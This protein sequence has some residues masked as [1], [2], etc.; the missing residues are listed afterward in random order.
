RDA[1][2]FTAIEKQIVPGLFARNES[3]PIRIWVVGC[4]TGEEVYS[5]VMLLSEYAST[6]TNPAPISVFAT[7]ID[8]EA[9]AFARTGLY[10]DTIAEQMTPERL[11]RFFVREGSGYRIAKHLREMV[12]FAV[13]N[14]IQD[15]PFS[16]VDLVSCRNV[17]IY[18]NR[19]LQS[20]VLDL[21]HFALRP[22]GTLILGMSESVEDGHDGF[23]PIDKTHRIFAQQPRAR[24][25]MTVGSLP[26]VHNARLPAEMLS[27]GGRRLVGYGEL[28]HRM[29]EHYAPPSL[30]V[31]DRLDIVHLSDNAGHYLRFTSG[32]PSMNLFKAAVDEL[33]YELKGAV[34]QAMR[35]MRT[36]DRKGLPFRRGPM[37]VSVDVKV[38]PIR[39]KSSARTYALIIFTEPSGE[40]PP[41]ARPEP[42]DDDNGSIAL[43]QR[44]H[45]MEAQLRTAVEQYE[46]QNEE[47]KASN[48][49]LQ[50][51]NEELRAT[52]EELETGK[53]ELQSINEELSTVN[54][55]LKNK[56]DETT[57]VSDDL[58]NFITATGIAALFID[59]DMRV[60]RYTPYA[61]QVFNLIPTDLGRPLM[62]I[63]HR[64]ID[65]DLAATIA[66]VFETLH[67]AEHE[68]RSNDDRWF[69]VRVLP[70][71]TND[72][73]IRGAVVT[74]VDITQ[75]RRVEAR[76][77]RSA[78]WAE[79]VVDS[80]HDYAILTLDEHGVIKTWNAGAEIIFGYSAS[81]II[82]QP[83]EL[84]FTPED[85]AAGVPDLEMRTA[86]QVGRA[87]DERWQ[88]RKDGT[89]F[90]ASGIAAPLDDPE[91]KGYVKLL[92][93]LTAQRMAS[94]RRDELLAQERRIRSAAE[95]ANQTKDEFLATLSHELRNPLA[96]ILMQSEIL[97]RAPEL[98]RTPRLAAAADVI[99]QTVRA[100]S[101]FVDDLLDVS[102]AR[103]GK[104]TIDRQLVPLP[105]LIA[106][107]IGALRH[108][109]DANDI[110]L[111]V[112][113]PK[114]P[115]IIAADAVRVKQIAWN[116]L[117]NAIKFTPQ[118]GRVSVRLV[119][120]GEQV[121]L[122]VEDTGEGIS[123][124]AMPMIFEWF[125]QVDSSTTRKRGG[126]GIGLALVK[127]LVELHGGRV[128]AFSEGRGK[129]ARFTVYLPAQDGYT[130]A[131]SRG[132][133]PAN[134]AVSRLS[135]V[136]LLVIDDA[137]GNADAMRELLQLEGAAVAIET[138]AREAIRRAQQE[139]FDVIIS[140]IAMP[141]M[142]GYTMLAKLRDGK[143]NRDSPAIAYSGYGGPEEIERS[144]KAGFQLHMVK[145]VD[146]D[147]LVE[148]IEKLYRTKSA[149]AQ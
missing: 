64:L 61:R 10:P 75:R 142:D 8:E 119:R 148:S 101:K 17:L 139:T 80:V 2:A 47:L 135:G 134:T 60:M 62:D 79:L 94:Q 21:L 38:H 76:G 90:F 132:A 125:K 140:D 92:R 149:S 31:D 57:R 19:H 34:E 54:Q 45:D 55:E 56:V 95:E 58:H 133:A 121:R 99:N 11:R 27:A 12:M 97:T 73:R 144:R 40:S 7:D 126:M 28:H 110:T 103:T 89:T 124:E 9:L 66:H 108:E 16:R 138:T 84:L 26:P 1:N 20:K 109:A 15:P 112:E 44:L 41:P 98:K 107:S 13:H 67:Q 141:E 71:R 6:M 68:V 51:T 23:L 42:R 111:E 118:G 52:T 39:D 50:A 102:R 46:V 115:I 72:D 137:A 145:P 136:R 81:E 59:R 22:D 96:L 53:E 24:M 105:F 106:D 3:E 86:R 122:D 25:G 87:E 48:E 74:L 113:L 104:L 131:G 100:Q 78:A 49:E 117:S 36:V 147:R 37:M 91:Q 35:A 70:Y 128:E 5:L 4:A 88:L 69:I 129:G 93:D 29:L 43:E 130:P 14:V 146:L 143:L 63:T 83:F 114:E 82:G 30:V 123:R 32:E 85:R 116:L 33:R 127:Q 77:Q 65:L 18:L 120:E